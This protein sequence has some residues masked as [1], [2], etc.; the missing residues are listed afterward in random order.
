LGGI[1]SFWQV[2]VFEGD[3]V[4]ALGNERYR[5]TGG[6]ESET[7]FAL[8]WDVSD[9]LITH[10]LVVEDLTL[11][12]GG[13]RAWKPLPEAAPRIPLRPTLYLPASA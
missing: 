1:V 5:T 3:Q 13:G 10:L 8:V 4:L 2:R 6:I 9:G 12:L 11:V 7:D